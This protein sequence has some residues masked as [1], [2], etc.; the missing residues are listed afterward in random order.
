[1]VTFIVILFITLLLKP[2]WNSIFKFIACLFVIPLVPL[3]LLYVI[4]NA[5]LPK[6]E[7]PIL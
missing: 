1:M 4:I 6:K 3:W 2:F 5:F 7:Q